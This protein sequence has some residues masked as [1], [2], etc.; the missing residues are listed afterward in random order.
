VLSL[1]LAL[2]S[3][4][5]QPDVQHDHV[6]SARLIWEYWDGVTWQTLTVEDGTRTLSHSGLVEFLVPEGFRSSVQF[7]LD[8]YWLR[9]RWEDGTHRISPRLRQVLLNTMMAAQTVTLRDEILGSSNG[10]AL[11]SFRTTRSP[12]LAGQVLEVREANAWMRWQ[13]VP[14]FHGSG[15]GDRHYVLHH[16]TGEIQFGDGW[17]GRVPPTGVGNLRMTCYQSGGGSLGNRGVGNIVELKTTLP[18]IDRVMNPEAAAGGADAETLAELKERAPRMVRHGGRA[19]TLEDYEDLAMLASPAVARVKCVPLRRLGEKPQDRQINPGA[20]S[21]IVV[22]E[23]KDLK[24]LPSLEL[25][26]RVQDYLAARALPTVNLAVVG[27]LYV[28]VDVDVEVGLAALE[29]LEA[30][31]TAIHQALTQFLHP[32]TGGFEGTGWP[33]GREPYRSD[34]YAL[35]EAIPGVDHVRSLQVTETLDQR[36]NEAIAEEEDLIRTKEM[37][38]FLVYSGAHRVRFRRSLI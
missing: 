31:E 23:S 34:F 21:V 10:A 25:L 26:N 6:S 37:G 38:R 5:Y 16:L 22:P 27:P 2:Y 24:P 28:K 9:L 4:L 20:V 32:L 7:G 19:V 3:H 8:Q 36:L 13:E 35:L 14:D 11:Q 29:G 17:K 33:F 18:Y 15:A 1:Y 30:V 12:V